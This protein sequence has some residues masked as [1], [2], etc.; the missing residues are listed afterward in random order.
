MLIAALLATVAVQAAPLDR[1]LAGSPAAQGVVP[2]IIDLLESNQ[3]A[4]K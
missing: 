3:V 1:C 4:T 2:A